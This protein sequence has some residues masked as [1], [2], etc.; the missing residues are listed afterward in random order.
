MIKNI[1]LTGAS[2]FL[3]KEVS[4]I[5][6]KKKY[7]YKA[8]CSDSK[9]VAGHISR[10][11]SNT[12]ELINLLT[13][14]KPSI[15]INLA[16]KVSFSASMSE[17]YS[18]N[19]LSPAIIADFCL[20]NDS[21]LVQASSIAVNGINQTLYNAN[22]VLQPNTHYGKSKLLAE[23]LIFESGC[24]SAVLRFGGI[25]G[26][27]GPSHLG[28]NKAIINA[29]KGKRPILYGIGDVK[30]NYIYVKD[31]AEAIVK[32]AEEKLTG[33]HYLGGEEKP[34][35]DMLSDICEVLIPGQ[36]PKHIKGEITS[37]QIVENSPLF[38]ITSFRTAIEQMA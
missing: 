22:S 18:L 24:G 31:A 19:I 29:K 36:F 2:G 25:F 23:N 10:D 12:L 38:E 13:K 20:K 34:L 28:I 33:I 9:F 35:R 27:N 21:F 5:L 32:C 17:L 30:R 15:V 6:S 11:L 26:S 3:G 4:Q 14:E 7:S 1:I 37:D 8:I 16:A